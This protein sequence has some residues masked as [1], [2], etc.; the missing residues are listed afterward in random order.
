LLKT[1][2]LLLH[3]ENDAYF[4]RD[5]ACSLPKCLPDFVYSKPNQLAYFAYEFAFGTD[6][7]AIYSYNPLAPQ[8]ARQL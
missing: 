2:S 6:K 5:E 4:L 1:K 3:V 7:L 8:P